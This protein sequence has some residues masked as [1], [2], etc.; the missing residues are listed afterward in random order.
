MND[1]DH[2]STETGFEKKSSRDRQAKLNGLG[3]GR[4]LRIWIFA[5]L[6]ASIGL[7]AVNV[8]RADTG[9]DD[10]NLALSLLIQGRWKPSADQFR[11]FLANHEK[12]EK[13]ALGRL[14]L[15]LTWESSKTIARLARNCSNS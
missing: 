10:Y 3:L 1:L 8:A 12:H 15:G 4:V 13:A 5:F 6:A 2:T 7:S 9:L 14:Y 11:E